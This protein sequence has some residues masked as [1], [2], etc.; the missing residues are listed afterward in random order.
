MAAN[1]SLS[2]ADFQ[3]RRTNGEGS[4]YRRF[5]KNEHGE[6][7][8]NGYG[9][10]VPVYD[11]ITRELAKRVYGY[12]RSADDAVKC[13]NFKAQK[14]YLKLGLGFTETCAVALRLAQDFED[15]S[16]RENSKGPHD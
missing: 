1:R 6:K 7:V 4:V 5:L 9:A 10:E 3:R 8:F 14:L 15:K 12:G 13:R 16:I 2:I 11:P